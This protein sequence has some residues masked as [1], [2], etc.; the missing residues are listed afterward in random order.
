MHRAKCKWN[1]KLR[2]VQRVFVAFITCCCLSS[3]WSIHRLFHTELLHLSL[4]LFPRALWV[5]LKMS[6]SVDIEEKPPA[7][8]L[9]MNSSSRDSSSVNHASK[10]LPMAP[11][12]KNKKVRLRSIFPGGDKS[13]YPSQ[14]V[15]FRLSSTLDH[16]VYLFPVCKEKKI[17]V[18]NELVSRFLS[19]SF[20]KQEEREGTSWDIPTLRL[21]THH[22]CWLWCCNRRIHS[23]YRFHPMIRHINEDRCASKIHLSFESKLTGTHFKIHI[24]LN[25]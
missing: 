12:E 7:P 4:S 15:A 18:I 19:I 20:S 25:W 5:L 1:S 21:R 23:E 13:E 11:E 14:H 8:P 9:R 10:P 16:M 2:S 6:D 3:Y 22:S 24:S 17:D